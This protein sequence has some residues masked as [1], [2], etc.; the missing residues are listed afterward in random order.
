MSIGGRERVAPGTPTRRKLVEGDLLKLDYGVIKH[1]YY[2]DSARTVAV[3]K[4]SPDASRLLEETR[5]ALEKGI[6]AMGPGNR[7]SD[8]GSGPRGAAAPLGA[9]PPPA[10]V[11]P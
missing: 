11:S 8:I 7:S 2:G 3:G 1:G 9:A 10:A 5:V 6:A 4:V